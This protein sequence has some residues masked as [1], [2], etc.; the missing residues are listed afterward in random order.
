M[1]MR[2]ST[3]PLAAALLGAALSFTDEAGKREPE[4]NTRLVRW[5]TWLPGVQK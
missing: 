4:G 5:G 3:L 1:R 2:H